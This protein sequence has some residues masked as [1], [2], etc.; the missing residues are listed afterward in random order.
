[1]IGSLVSGRVVQVVGTN[2]SADTWNEI[3]TEIDD[4][5]KMEKNQ[6]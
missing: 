3:Y 2:M 5:L 6:S 1:M 4:I